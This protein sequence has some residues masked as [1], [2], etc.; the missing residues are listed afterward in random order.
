M[1][2]QPHGTG[3]LLPPSV[4]L[5]SDRG[6]GRD[7]HTMAPKAVPYLRPQLLGCIQ[8]L[9]VIF[10]N[11]IHLKPWTLSLVMLSHWKRQ[12]KALESGFCQMSYCFPPHEGPPAS[13][14][15]AATAEPSRN[16]HPAQGHHGSIPGT[17]GLFNPI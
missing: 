9:Q 12:N 8:P 13:H 3:A 7:E 11:K 17:Q 15:Q 6:Q 10:F 5:Q 16:L 4:T 2:L 1:V 14:P